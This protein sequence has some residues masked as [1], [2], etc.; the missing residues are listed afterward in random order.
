[1]SFGKPQPERFDVYTEL[2]NEKGFTIKG[3]NFIFKFDRHGGWKDQ[4]GNYYNC[5]GEP[6][7]E[8]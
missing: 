4:Y 8:P 5:N 2:A 3:C 6:E 1:M 7:E